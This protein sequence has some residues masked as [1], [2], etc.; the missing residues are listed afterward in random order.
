MLSSYK[1]SKEEKIK[2]DSGGIYDFNIDNYFGDN[3][4]FYNVSLI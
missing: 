3:K 4:I 1:R 2:N